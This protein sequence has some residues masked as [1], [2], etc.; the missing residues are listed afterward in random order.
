LPITYFVLRYS[1][2]VPAGEVAA[3]YGIRQKPKEPMEKKT[4]DG[5]IAA[6]IDEKPK[7]EEKAEE[8]KVP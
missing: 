2:P 6:V 5:E 1:K 7:E 3:T 8:K 4:L